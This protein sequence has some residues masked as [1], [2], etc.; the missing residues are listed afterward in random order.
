MKWFKHLWRAFWGTKEDLRPG[1]CECGHKRCCHQAGKGACY[2]AT[3]NMPRYACAC[4]I[5]I[6]KK[7]DGGD[8]IPTPQDLEKL[9]S[10]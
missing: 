1:T 5:Y 7:D 10:R 3:P 4:T 6:P 2:V 9:Y 8:F